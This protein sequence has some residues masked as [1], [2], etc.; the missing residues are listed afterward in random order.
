MWKIL[1]FA[2]FAVVLAAPLRA[3]N[4]PDGD[5]AGGPPSIGRP[6]DSFSL[7]TGIGDREA[8][9]VRAGVQWNWR[10]R[11]LDSGD[12]HLGGYW[13]LSVGWWHGGPKEFAEIAFTPTF[14]YQ[15]SDRGSPYVEAA[16][17]LHVLDSVHV[18]EDRSFS[19]RFQFGDHVGAGI[20]F[21]PRGRYDLGVRLQHLSNAGIRNPN[22]GI[23]FLQLRLQV[24]VD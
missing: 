23:N 17:G 18:A 19:S 12:W 14:R 2:I 4:G 16:I 6:I 1:L 21:G 15:R 20:R 3:A 24:S 11:W 10:R 22:P 13:D 7:E 9:I 8:S 5:R